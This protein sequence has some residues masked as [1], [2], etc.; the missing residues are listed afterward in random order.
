[1][2]TRNLWRF[3]WLYPRHIS[4]NINYQKLQIWVAKILAHT[5]SFNG[6]NS[7]RTSLKGCLAIIFNPFSVFVQNDNMSSRHGENVI[8]IFSFRGPRVL[9]PDPNK[10]KHNITTT[11]SGEIVYEH[12]TCCWINVTLIHGRYGLL[13]IFYQQ[14]FTK[15]TNKLECKSRRF[16]VIVTPFSR[17]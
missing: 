10:Y 13:P 4:G 7:Q 9:V 15:A 11:I 1:M 6:S 3:L 14:R 2:V 16:G 12:Y 5:S 17:L 8:I